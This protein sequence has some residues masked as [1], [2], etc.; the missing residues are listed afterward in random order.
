MP[1]NQNSFFF[2][3]SLVEM[4]TK[5]GDLLPAGIALAY[6]INR[7][8]EAERI[9]ASL[10]RHV[11]QKGWSK[12]SREQGFS[13]LETK[14]MWYLEVSDNYLKAAAILDLDS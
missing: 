4:F 7:E 12:A 13:S 5:Q 1:I 10:Q 9:H 3:Q 2:V 6:A 14:M 11:A 8:E